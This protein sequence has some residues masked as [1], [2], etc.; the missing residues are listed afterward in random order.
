MKKVVLAILLVAA[1]VLPLA[2]IEVKSAGLEAGYRHVATEATFAVDPDFDVYA[3]MGYDFKKGFE[4]GAGVNYKV[5]EISLGSSGTALPLKVGGFV[6][7]GLK[8]PI[9]IKALGTAQVSYTFDIGTGKGLEVYSRFG[10]G[11]SFNKTDKFGFAW[12]LVAGAA[13]NF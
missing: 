8:T 6:G 4:V 13:Y 1:V 12:T 3:H 9:S 5:A 7:V 2:A 10:A 11:F